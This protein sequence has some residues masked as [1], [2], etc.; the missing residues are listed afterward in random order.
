MRHCQSKY[1]AEQGPHMNGSNRTH[2]SRDDH[3]DRVKDED[4]RMQVR[5]QKWGGTMW[6]IRNPF[7]VPG[8]AYNWR[9]W[10][11]MQLPLALAPMVAKGRDCEAA[12]SQH[13]WYNVDGKRS[14]CY[15]CQIEREGQLWCG[16]GQ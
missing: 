1:S 10:L 11:R 6:R 13:L 16:M 14:G 15:H 3:T 5:N 2:F 9:T 12:G 4:S 8:H 7:Y